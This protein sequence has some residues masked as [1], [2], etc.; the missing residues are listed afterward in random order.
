MIRITQNIRKATWKS[1]ILEHKS[2]DRVRIF[3]HNVFLQQ[4]LKN[5]WEKRRGDWL[6]LLGLLWCL[7]SIKD[8]IYD[9]AWNVSNMQQIT[10]N[11]KKMGFFR[12]PWWSA[13]ERWKCSPTCLKVTTTLD[14]NPQPHPCQFYEYFK[15]NHHCDEVQ[16]Y[17]CFDRKT[18]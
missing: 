3:F 17:F 5:C 9:D 4:G 16:W 2:K 14:I 7:G 8:T 15:K 13:L 1:K 11:L 12:H 6:V 10:P 18:I